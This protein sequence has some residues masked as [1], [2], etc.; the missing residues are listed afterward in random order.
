MDTLGLTASEADILCAFAFGVTGALLV[1]T[2]LWIVTAAPRMRAGPGD[3]AI[4][5]GLV[6]CTAGAMAAGHPWPAAWMALGLAC[7]RGVFA[8]GHFLDE[9]HNPT[10]RLRSGET[11]EQRLARREVRERRLVEEAIRRYRQATE[12]GHPTPGEPIDL[13]PWRVPDPSP[14]ALPTATGEPLDAHFTDVDDTDATAS[15]VGSTPDDE[16]LVRFATPIDAADIEKRPDRA[17]EAMRAIIA[18]LGDGSR[19]VGIRAKR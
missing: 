12:G 11:M 5:A 14:P 9:W 6:L 8:F 18:Q 10:D 19:I 15:D 13:T 1:L 17:R 16:V 7:V 2:G 4:S 3:A